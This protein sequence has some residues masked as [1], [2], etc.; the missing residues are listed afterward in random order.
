M[1]TVELITDP[2]CPN[3]EAT[4]TQLRRALAALDLPVEWEEWDRASPDAPAHA[5]RYGS[6]TVLVNG[7]DVVGDGTEADAN[8]CRVYTDA[9]G[10]LQGTPSV[11]AI[12]AALLR[13]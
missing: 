12:K 10:G 2:D 7:R 5:L 11:E 1:K 4:R 9:D 13:D 3:V 8:C 6:P